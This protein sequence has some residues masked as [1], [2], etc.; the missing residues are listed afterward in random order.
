MS[1]KHLTNIDKAYEAIINRI[2]ALYRMTRNEAE[3]FYLS[4]S[5]VLRRQLEEELSKL[6]NSISNNILAG[7]T[8]AW[9]AA[10]NNYNLEVSKQIRV[11][12][13][14]VMSDNAFNAYSEAS[15][16]YITDLEKRLSKSVWKMTEQF[17]VEIELQLQ[18]A[19]KQG[20]SANKLASDMKKYLVDP[21]MLFRRVR[22]E[23]G[24]LHLSKAAKAYNPGQGRYRSSYKNARRMAS[25]EINRAYCL[26]EHER[27]L[28]D[29]NVVGI[30]IKLSN[31]HTL[32]GE[33]FNDMCDR[34][35]GK[36]AKEFVFT[37][38]HPHCRCYAVSIQLTDEEFDRSLEDV[39]N[40]G[41]GE[42]ESV[43]R[44]TGVPDNYKEWCVANKERARGWK[45]LPYFVKDNPAYSPDFFN[46]P[47][48][49][50]AEK[51]FARHPSTHT[52]ISRMND[53][54]YKQKYKDL[55]GMEL[56]SIHHYTRSNTM[57]YR[58]LNKSLVTGKSDTFNDAF[59]ELLSSGLN[60]LPNFEGAVYRG[61]ILNKVQLS[62]YLDAHSMGVAYT[63]KFFTSG[64]QSASVAEKF[65]ELRRL[66]KGESKC[67]FLIESKKGKAL[68]D[69]SEF[70]GKFARDNQQEVVF[71]K[72]T[73]YD[74]VKYTK[75]SDSTYRFHLKEI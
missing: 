48:Y 34:L 69:I 58:G 31:N 42:V 8:A 74:V 2:A 45:D 26:G 18:L 67:T 14:A 36:Y 55:T 20:V 64:S 9:E 70:N 29:S 12:A 24:Q 75:T 41:D 15:A 23:F 59:S 72:N 22:D 68:G 4:K 65:T 28:S 27:R 71:D 40:G 3:V 47:K 10:N 73:M 7:V 54:Y 13:V 33:P 1:G 53:P 6:G 50:E 51:I 19:F 35:A 62:A 25:T 43:N 46:T 16:K 21:D 52:A 61:S 44:V 11:K 5:P 38:W 49:T 30:E 37:K 66:K 57:A 39:L 17:K 32:N 56:S 63:H 60:K